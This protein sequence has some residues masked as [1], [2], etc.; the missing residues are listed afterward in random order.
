MQYKRWLA[1]GEGERSKAIIDITPHFSNREGLRRW[2]DFICGDYEIPFCINIQQYA[3]Q[4]EQ[5][6][7]LAAILL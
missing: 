1:V 7:G 4:K 3:I 5:A 2:G 6:N